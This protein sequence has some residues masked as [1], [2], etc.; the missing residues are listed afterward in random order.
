MA[1]HQQIAMQDA[2]AAL[3]AVNMRGD[4]QIH[5][6][7][8]LL[9]ASKEATSSDDLLLRLRELCLPNVIA[10]KNVTNN[11]TLFLAIRQLLT[12]YSIPVHRATWLSIIQGVLDALFEVNQ[13]MLQEAVHI[14]KARAS[15]LTSNPERPSNTSHYSSNEYQSR[16]NNTASRNAQDVRK[17]F[18]HAQKF[19]GKMGDTPSFS[20]IRNQF[21]DVVAELEIRPA[22]Q[23]TLIRSNL[24]EEAYQFYQ[25]VIKDK[26]NALL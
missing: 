25:E 10:K 22:L 21:M 11:P 20:E 5:L 1:D 19:S 4:D 12:A 18:P 3:I 13:E 17:R 2:N 23:V 8:F 26:V 24:R 7:D 14:W 15:E 16:T 9:S 6:I